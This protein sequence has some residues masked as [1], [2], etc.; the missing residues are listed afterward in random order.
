MRREDSGTPALRDLEARI[1]SLEAA[2]HDKA[3]VEA[4]LRDSEERFALILRGTNDGWWDWDLVTDSLFF[5]PRWWGIIGHE[6]GELPSTSATWKELSHPEDNERVN[7]AYQQA[8]ARG[9]DQFEVESRRRHKDGH[10][11]PV[12]TR[13]HITRSSA[14]TPLRISGTTTD[15]SRQKRVED[16]LRESEQRFRSMVETTLA[17]IWAIDDEGRTT[18]VNACMAEMLGYEP[19]E[20]LGQPALAFMLEQD[21]AAH[22]EATAR[23]HAGQRDTYERGFRRKD[24]RIIWTII[25]G[26]PLLSQT[27]EFRGSFATLTEITERKEAEEHLR[28]LAELLDTAP[29]SITVHDTEGRFLYANRRTFEIH[30]WSESEFMAKTLRDVDVPESAALIE[31]RM[32]RIAEKGEARF[33]V[34]HLRSDGTTVPLEVFVKRALW[35]GRP[36]LLSIATDITERKRSEAALAQQVEELQRWYS[37]TLGREKRIGELKGEVN[38]LAGRLGLPRPYAASGGEGAPD[39][40]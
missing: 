35:A 9:D 34:A 38:E 17:G 25:N 5:S 37:A 40:T 26:T 10:W 11:V 13:G 14:G 22:R 4:Q 6:P 21:A 18:F 28:T 3:A 19:E 8:L 31:E 23:R 27:G 33:E 2:L 20:M 16:A 29:N 15:L 7:H 30:G 32:R 1:A 24:G 12:L 39:T 36:V